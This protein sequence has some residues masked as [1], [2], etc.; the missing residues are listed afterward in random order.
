MNTT[1]ICPSCGKPLAPNAPKGLCAA[2]LLQAG[3][4]TG[5]DW[6]TDPETGPARAAFVPPSVA[7]L[8]G[9]FPQLEIIELIGQG[10]MGAVYKARQPKLNRI[11]ALKILPPVI[12][13][14]PAF[15]R[16]FTREAQ[17][18]AQLNHPGI[19]TLYEFGEANGQFYF[20]MEFV[21]GVNLRQLL[22]GGRIA[23]R[24]AL[25]IVPQICDALQFAHDQGIVHRDIKPENILLDRRGRVKVADFGLAKIMGGPGNEP[26][27]A[28]SGAASSTTST[29]A[30]KVMGTPQ[31][32]SPEQIHAPGE[33]DHRADIYALG[34][35]FYQML[36]G[37][38]P[39][40]KIEAPSKKV[41]LD[42]RLDE[43][44]L[45]A[46]EKTPELRYQQVGEVKTCVETIVATPPGGR[47]DEAAEPEKTARGKSGER[48]GAAFL[49]SERARL[50]VQEFS[51]APV[52]YPVMGEV[53]LHPDRLVVWSSHNQH[54][55]P[56]TAIHELGE[57]VMPFGESPGPHRYAA[58]AFD[59]AGQRRHLVF[60]AGSSAVRL[61]GDTRR[62]AAEWLTAIQRAIKS[63]TGRDVPIT[64]EP[65]V[66][67]VKSWRSLIWL[68]VPLLA[69]IPWLANVLSKRGPGSLSVMNAALLSG[70]FML[71]PGVTLIIV[72]IVRSCSLRHTW[73]KPLGSVTASADVLPAKPVRP[74]SA[75]KLIAIGSFVVAAIVL[76]LAAWH[77]ASKR[78]GEAQQQLRGALQNELANQLAGLLSKQLPA[79]YSRFTFEHVPNWPWRAVV[80]FEKLESW[81][82]QNNAPL[83]QPRPLQGDVLLDF[84]APNQWS[85]TGTGDLTGVNGSWQTATP[86]FPDWPDSS[87]AAQTVVFGP[88]MELTL[89]DPATNMACVLDLE[90]GRLLKPPDAL[91]ELF[92]KGIPNLDSAGLEWLRT[93]GADVVLNEPGHVSV[94]FIGGAAASPNGWIWDAITPAMVVALGQDL[95][96]QVFQMDSTGFHASTA[97]APAVDCFVTRKGSLGVMEIRGRANNPPGVK[98][99]YKLVQT[100][101]ATASR[102]DP[103]LL[104]ATPSLPDLSK[105]ERVQQTYVVVRG[106]SVASI[107]R[108]FRMSIRDLKAFNPDLVVNRLKIGQ[109]LMVSAPISNDNG[110]DFVAVLPTANEAAVHDACLRFVSARNL[111]PFETWSPAGMTLQT[112][113]DNGKAVTF[114]FSRQIDATTRFTIHATPG[115]SLSALE[116]GAQLGINQLLQI[117]APAATTNALPE[118]YGNQTQTIPDTAARQQEQIMERMNAMRKFITG[119]IMYRDVHTN[120][121]PDTLAGTFPYLKG[122]RPEQLPARASAFRYQRP[123]ANLD[124][125][126]AA[127]TAVLFEKTP[128]RAGGQYLG[129]ADG[130][131]AFTRSNEWTSTVLPDIRPPA[132][133]PKLQFLAWQDE[134]QTNQPGAARHLDGSPV[135]DATELKWLKSISSGG[136]D[137]SSWHL[138]PEPR[139]L[140]LWFSDPKFDLGSFSEV[141]LLDDQ[142]QVIPLDARGG[143]C[144]S[145]QEGN[146]SNG[147]LGWHVKTFSPGGGARL[148]ARVTVSLRYAAGP[149]EETQ[150]VP[151]TPHNATS[152]TLKDGSLLNGV[153]QNVDG[154]AFVAI[155]VH[156]RQPGTWRFGVVA[157][158][159]DGRKL[160]T[161]PSEN[162]FADGSGESVAEF[163][164]GVP[165]AE[166]DKFIIGTRPIRT[167]EWKHVM[168]PNN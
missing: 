35:V 5:A 164:F 57:A 84:Q 10:G 139:F 33:V 51:G 104:P 37:E 122:V 166:V 1:P 92:A 107:A 89:P 152:M 102:D 32:M 54:S 21:D 148:P 24:E 14:E 44:V 52:K 126:A 136:V 4:G 151:F 41:Q 156:A 85:A 91:V 140:K 53:T 144:G 143:M 78:T 168:L 118:Q 86:G 66:V 149:L 158:T 27:P 20:L 88:V 116:I 15:A 80:H 45:R 123:E 138:S 67:P 58:V 155:A 74:R 55:I 95:R 71:L 26:D 68:L 134:W 131:V 120:Q 56:M 165:L 133:A 114:K 162:G 137:V 63:A 157:V 12:G 62:H 34:V 125:N 7:A 135:T 96:S 124:A 47:P 105:P 72:F 75:G 159:K 38:L 99:R 40:Q 150:A 65:A 163:E 121:W 36:T 103:A 100:A 83:A 130:H 2:C 90:S 109:S 70:A 147:N 127:L 64:Q 167:N 77:L 6:G 142:H 8:A 16:R 3:L 141:S 161:A 146:E 115:A 145:A 48:P 129:Y 117:Q 59:E 106:D 97:Q 43:I 69:T 108:K 73:M 82:D 49:K 19:V 93:N 30:S 154:N 39:G 113:D 128:L 87:A 22:Q 101:S 81:R 17:A 42:V 79:M 111:M 18:L 153:G 50:A 119:M 29:E 60:L 98:L 13:N 112:A 110:H 94:R 9:N 28:G 11:V 23:A 31:Y 132:T 61:P 76:S 160:T 46:L 25:A